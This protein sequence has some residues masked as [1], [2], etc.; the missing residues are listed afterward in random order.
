MTKE[1]Q[2]EVQRRLRVR[3]RQIHIVLGLIM[4]ACHFLSFPNT[5]KCSCA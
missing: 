5:K 1:D 3:D 2:R 4:A